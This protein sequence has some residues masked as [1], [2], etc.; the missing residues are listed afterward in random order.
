MPFLTNFN[1]GTYDA[2]TALKDAGAVTASG[3]ATVSS[4]AR[5]VDLG[6]SLPTSG[7]SVMMWAAAVIDVTAID[8]S[9]GDELYNIVI[10]GCNTSG[11][12]SGEIAPLAILC[13]GHSSKIIG[14]G[15]TSSVTG[16][17]VVPFFNSAHGTVFRYVRAYHE[18]SGTSPS[19]NYT[20]FCIPMPR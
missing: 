1:F 8:V 14:A 17:Y 20:A 13:L 19:I 12:G 10:E 16:R 11:F 15:A 9:S 18:I 6:A 5:E 2:T 3:A 7:Q 4:V